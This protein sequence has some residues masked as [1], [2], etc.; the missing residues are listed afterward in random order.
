MPTQTQVI[1]ACAFIHKEGKLFLAKRAAT[2]AFLPNKY[3]LVGGHV[4]FGET[5]EQALAREIQEEIRLD[6]II[7]RPF[8]AFTYL[9]KD[10]TEHVVEIDYFARMKDESE[11]IHL[12]PEDHSEYHWITEE[13]ID[14]YLDP[15]D[16]ETKAIR[17]GFY[18]LKSASSLSKAAM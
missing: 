10:E 8:H 5:L 4:E 2:K 18:L 7:E 13:E 16:D 11:E 1:T 9:A 12:N 6:V 3:E 17:E 15:E 14:Q